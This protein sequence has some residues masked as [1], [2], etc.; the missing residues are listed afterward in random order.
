MELD[1]RILIYIF[2]GVLPSLTWLSYYLTKDMHPEPKRMILKIF[3]WGALITIPVFF[4]QIGCTYLLSLAKIDP[5]LI[6]IIY[7]FLVISLTEELFKYF[8]VKMKVMNSPHLDEPLDIM[9]Y[10]VVAA[11]GFA[12]LENVLYLFSPIENLPL[13]DLISRTMI[14]AL[15]RFVG[16]TFLHTLCSAVV[17]YALAISCCDKKNRFLEFIS[18]L[19]IATFLHGLYDFSI[20]TLRG[21]AQIAIPVITILVLAIMVF[22]GFEKLKKIK[23]V[24]ILN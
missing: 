21:Y 18:G 8:V 24:T 11:L 15:V 6:S 13:N 3:L 16:A 4:V 5:L 14:I 19:I 23:S 2:F 7:W 22:T 10:I 17:G 9:L 12:A 20:M 1:Y